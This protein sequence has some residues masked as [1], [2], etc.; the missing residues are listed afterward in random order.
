MIEATAKLGVS[1]QTVLQRVKRGE[2]KAV[3]VRQGRRKGL[4]IKVVDHSHNSFS[5]QGAVWNRIQRPTQFPCFDVVRPDVFRRSREGFGS[6]ADDD[7]KIF[8]NDA[9]TRQHIRLLQRV[10]ALI[11]PQIDPAVLSERRNW[12]SGSS[13]QSINL[14]LDCRKTR[15][16]LPADQ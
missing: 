14:A 9:G 6:P 16:S 10:T 3:L 13:I 12:P 5:N 4:R 11:L 7:Q 1:R 2:L 8:K 15:W